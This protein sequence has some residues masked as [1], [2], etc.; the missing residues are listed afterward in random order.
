MKNLAIIYILLSLGMGANKECV[1]GL[2]L[3]RVPLK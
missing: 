3:R 1:D 2:V